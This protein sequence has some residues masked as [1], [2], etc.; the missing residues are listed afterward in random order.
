M[1]FF[2]LALF[3]GC[4]YLFFMKIKFCIICGKELVAKEAEI[5]VTCFSVL[6]NKYPKYNDLKEVIKW[7]K[8]NLKDLE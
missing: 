4:L 8:N 5:C 7:H 2:S 3:I 1:N 6:I